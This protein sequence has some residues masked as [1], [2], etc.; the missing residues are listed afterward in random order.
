[1]GSGS[2]VTGGSMN[3]GG[4]TG[5]PST[6]GM[7][8]GGSGGGV[9][10]HSGGDSAGTGEG[11][12]GTCCGG[13]GDG[14]S[15]SAGATGAASGG[16]T[17]AVGGGNCL[18]TTEVCDGIDNDCDGVVDQAPTCPD[19][20]TGFALANHGYMYCANTNDVTTA[21]LVCAQ[22][23]MHLAWLESAAENAAVV[24]AVVKIADRPYNGG[25]QAGP[26]IGG[27]DVVKE[28]SWFW[29]DGTPF[30]SGGLNGSP[31]GG[32][33]SNWAH[34]EPNDNGTAASG[35]EDCIELLLEDGV[36]GSRG[37]WNDVSCNW[38]IYETL[39]ERL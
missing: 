10:D 3:S 27:T 37:Q 38:T 33:F 1:M 16:A 6:G 11:G 32:A 5:S 24:T 17:G 18:K 35:G 31:V 39:C 26:F 22:Q 34:D 28:G 15:A 14:G 20:C 23:M 29:G 9:E 19:G 8:M 7:M 2:S 25:N 30:W 12:L 36:I 4:P 13:P 21:M